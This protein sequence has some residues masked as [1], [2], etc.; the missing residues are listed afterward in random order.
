MWKY[1]RVLHIASERAF[2]VEKHNL[3]AERGS[4]GELRREN[5]I[6]SKV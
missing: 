5:Q 3:A 1:I 2:V 6:I 4:G